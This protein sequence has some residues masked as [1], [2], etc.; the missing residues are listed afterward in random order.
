MLYIAEEDGQTDGST[1]LG[2]PY[3]FPTVGFLFRRRGREDEKV[4]VAAGLVVVD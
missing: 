2:E 4:V 3:L 1:L